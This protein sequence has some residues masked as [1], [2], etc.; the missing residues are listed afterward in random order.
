MNYY[1]TNTFLG[2]FILY[3]GIIIIGLLT[4]V[5]AFLLSDY[6][7][8]KFKFK[9]WQKKA[10]FLAILIF[11]GGTLLYL[12]FSWHSSVTDGE[13]VRVFFVS[14]KSQ[15]R[16][17]VLFR[18]CERPVE[19]RFRF[20]S[21][22]FYTGKRTRYLVQLFKPHIIYRFTLFEPF[23]NNKI[24]FY[25]SALGLH[26][27]DLFTPEN[28][29]DEEKILR[30]NPCLK[31]AIKP[32]WDDALDESTNS[33]KVFN[34][35]GQLFLIDTNL[36]AHK[37]DDLGVK[38]KADSDRIGNNSRKSSRKYPKWVFKYFRRSAFRV[39]H[40]AGKAP[41]ADAV[42]M[43]DPEIVDRW[44]KALF[45]SDK[46]WV[47][48]FSEYKRYA[49]LYLSYLDSRGREINRIDIRKQFKSHTRPFGVYLLDGKTYL[50]M[51][52]THGN[53]PY[54]LFALQYNPQTGRIIKRID[55]F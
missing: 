19:C 32:N 42:K 23:K 47:W 50:F 17:T 33:I 40:V 36:V 30:K 21:Y 11:T 20:R 2:E 18:G 26:L 28:L 44:H 1:I 3:T 48:Y 10:T 55:Y 35:N 7:F 53:E 25:H 15:H 41:A 9:D 31:G 52:R 22:D 16:I 46:I 49:P 43:Y 4:I 54:S 13:I 37:I 51:T 39:L 34:N 24:W 12:L 8:R 6:L 38:P 5:G 29:G 14:R 45:A 27:I